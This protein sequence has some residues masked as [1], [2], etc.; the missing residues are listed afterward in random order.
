MRTISRS[1]ISAEAPRR[2][3]SLAA[4]FAYAFDGLRA[5]WRTQRNVRVHA[6]LAVLALA[7]AAM[8]RVPPW[9]WAVVVLSIALVIAVELA[10]TAIEALVDL[11]SPGDHPL[12]KRAKDVAAAAVLVA[13]VGAAGAGACVVAALLRR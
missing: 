13:S 5:A 1:P 6:V 12:A 2:T 10:N 9:A 7:A 4:A 3:H 8:F 11:V